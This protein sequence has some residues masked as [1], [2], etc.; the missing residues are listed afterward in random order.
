[1]TDLRS[2]GSVSVRLH[3]RAPRLTGLAT[4]ASLLRGLAALLLLLAVAD[5][6]LA[7]VC[8]GDGD[9]QPGVSEWAV[10]ELE[11]ADAPAA[12]APEGGRHEHPETECIDCFCC[13]LKP[14]PEAGFVAVTRLAEPSAEEPGGFV[15]PSSPPRIPFHPPRSA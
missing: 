7:G 12:R 6:A 13:S 11:S 5:V 14:L 2:R 8:C 15:F 3:M 10:S 1:M 4:P 9:D